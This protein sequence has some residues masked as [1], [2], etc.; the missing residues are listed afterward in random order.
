MMFE[1]F[2][3]RKEKPFLTIQGFGGGAGGNSQSGTT[4]PMDATGGT[5]S[6][7]S[8]PGGTWKCHVFLESG[9]FVVNELGTTKQ[10]PG[11]VDT[12]QYLCVG[13]G[14]GGACE[15]GGGGGAGG[16]VVS[17]DF[18]NDTVPT[19]S[20]REPRSNVVTAKT[21][22]IFVG[23]GG[24]GGL[25]PPNPGKIGAAGQMSYIGPGAGSENIAESQG[26]GYGNSIEPTS[27]YPRPG[28]PGG[29]GGGGCNRGLP[30]GGSPGGEGHNTGSTDQQG[31][32]GG[33]GSNADFAGGGGGAGAV[34]ADG[35]P[36]TAGPGGDGLQVL[37]LGP[38][39]SPSP[40]GAPGPSPL[41]GYFAG[42]GGGGGDAWGN[43]G[44]GGGGR[45]GKLNPHPS[46]Q[47]AAASGT[48][49][50]GGGGGGTRRPGA[51]GGDGGTGIVV[52]RY[53]I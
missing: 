5:T 47:S 36:T 29:S 27:V 39:T 7:F 30:Y 18:P 37:I 21:Y 48:A 35:S 52:I 46:P 26:G 31:N 15:G 53:R 28:G 32:D 13:G 12:I 40:I 11:A 34:G 1:N 45:G 43:G 25:G 2:W 44:A 22:P 19:S 3:H 14:G 8:D 17:P 51:P 38:P 24:E 4:I 23:G 16:L 41:G 9:T 10:P 50:T 49:N 20:N 42:G 6:T 33:K